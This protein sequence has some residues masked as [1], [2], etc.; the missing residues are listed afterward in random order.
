MKS[1]AISHFVKIKRDKTNEHRNIQFSMRQPSSKLIGV[2][3]WSLW[4]KQ[5]QILVYSLF[6]I[7]F[8]SLCSLIQK[9]FVIEHNVEFKFHL[10]SWWSQ[11]AMEMVRVDSPSSVQRTNN[12]H[13]M[14]IKPYVRFF[15]GIFQFFCFAQVRNVSN[16]IISMWHDSCNLT[17]CK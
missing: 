11:N 1:A 13:I 14:R 6:W 8:F 2:A 16:R 5:H 12:S 7:H 10:P 4:I 3:L 15:G 17:S 9:P